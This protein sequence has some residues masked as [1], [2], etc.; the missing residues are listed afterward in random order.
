MSDAVYGLP[1]REPTLYR[2]A[3]IPRNE[4]AL[5]L[6]SGPIA[7]SKQYTTVASPLGP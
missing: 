5:Q 7:G 2:L 3:S 4:R 6:A 1:K